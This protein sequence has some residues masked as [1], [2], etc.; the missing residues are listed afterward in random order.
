MSVTN[1]LT[2][3]ELAVAR[4]LRSTMQGRVVLRGD[5]DYARRRQ[6]WNRAVESQP[7]L[8]AVSETSAD[9]QAAV[10]VA[11][12][13]GLPLSVRGGGNAARLRALKR[14]FDPDGVFASAIPLPDLRPAIAHP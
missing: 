1:I 5:E 14:R 3:S 2:T 6:I 13:H 9:V 4:E 10:R 7:A 11:R 12:R 8:F